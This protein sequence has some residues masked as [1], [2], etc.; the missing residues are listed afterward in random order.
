MNECNVYSRERGGRR[1]ARSGL[2]DLV[3]TSQL[4]DGLTRRGGEFDVLMDGADNQ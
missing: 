4:S 1:A 2:L 3:E